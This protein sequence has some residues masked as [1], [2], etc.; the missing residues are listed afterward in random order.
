MLGLCIGLWLGLGSSI[1]YFLALLF[2]CFKLVISKQ[3]TVVNTVHP[4]TNYTVSI[5]VYRVGLQ[6]Q[7]YYSNI[8]L[9]SVTN[10]ISSYFD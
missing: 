2:L 9:S 4:L 6:L 10:I 7:N 8:V 1:F 5:K 3:E